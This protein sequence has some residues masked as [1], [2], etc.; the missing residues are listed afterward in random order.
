MSWTDYAK[1]IAAL[2]LP[3]LGAALPLPGGAALGA[4]LASWIGKDSNT[5]P[6]DI[7]KELTLSGESLQKAKEFEFKHEEIMLK[8]QIDF[9]LAGQQAVNSTM[10]VE[11]KA[12]KWPQYSWRPYIGFVTG[13]MVF[14][15]YFVLPLS[16][17]PVPAVPESV[18]IMLASILG[19]ASY[20]RGKGKITDV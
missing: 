8:M 1:K 10:Q 11:A 13:T 5:S 17:I 20:W 19:V 7:V 3:A 14:G 2:G 18:W 9:E 12:E 15:I 6:E 4:A 16:K